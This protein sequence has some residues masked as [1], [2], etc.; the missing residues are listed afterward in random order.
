MTRIERVLAAFRREAVTIAQ[1][2]ERLGLR[3]DNVE[4]MLQQLIKRGELV[5]VDVATYARR[6]QP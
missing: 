4:Q 1:L 5:R 3:R 6:R 2:T